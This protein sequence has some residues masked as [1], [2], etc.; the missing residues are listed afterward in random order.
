[1]QVQITT[2]KYYITVDN[3]VMGDAAPYKAEPEYE[4][5]CESLDEAIELV[6]DKLTV[7]INGLNELLETRRNKNVTVTS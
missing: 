4:Q 2:P 6:R 7:T 5:K 3:V 1:M